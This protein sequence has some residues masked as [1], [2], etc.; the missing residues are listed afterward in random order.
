MPN[1]LIKQFENS[2]LGKERA[3]GKPGSRFDSNEHK[4]LLTSDD[5]VVVSQHGLDPTVPCATGTLPDLTRSSSQNDYALRRT[6]PVTSSYDHRYYQT[7]PGCGAEPPSIDLG[8]NFPSM[9]EEWKTHARY[10]SDTQ[11]PYPRS[12]LS[13]L[14]DPKTFEP[15][16]KYRSVD[17]SASDETY[18]GSSFTTCEPSR[19]SLPLIG[20]VGCHKLFIG[21]GG[22]TDLLDYKHSSFLDHHD[23]SASKISETPGMNMTKGLDSRPSLHSLGDA[24]DDP[25]ATL[26]DDGLRWQRLWVS[27]PSSELVP[28]SEDDSSQFHRGLLKDASVISNDSLESEE[29]SGYEELRP[30]QLM[31][32]DGYDDEYYPT[33]VSSRLHSDNYQKRTSVFSRLSK[34]P[35]TRRQ[36]KVVY[37]PY[38][39]LSLDQLL[40]VLSRRKDLL[41]DVDKMVPQKSSIQDDDQQFEKIA[42]TEPMLSTSVGEFETNSEEVAEEI[43]EIPFLNFKRRSEVQKVEGGNEARPDI[44][45]HR[46]E[47]SLRKR[48]RLVRPSFCEDECQDVQKPSQEIVRGGVLV[49][50]GEA[51]NTV[52]GDSSVRIYEESRNKNS[53]SAAECTLSCV[54]N[55]LKIGSNSSNTCVNDILIDTA[56]RCF[57]K[58]LADH[59]VVSTGN[60]KHEEKANTALHAG[61]VDLSVLQGYSELCV[62]KVRE[63][64]AASL[65]KTDNI[66]SEDYLAL[67]VGED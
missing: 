19:V 26:Q 46:G 34:A 17:V 40:S 23:S 22:C 27:G 59:S 61:G 39:N 50:N 31:H 8:M 63:V 16:S 20:S 44:E 2:Y 58:S 66:E 21:S 57:L 45:G 62:Q 38:R 37:E 24:H 6:F 49:K 64:N 32:D 56:G 30:Y 7:V 4:P 1:K 25:K 35:E 53:S 18:E 65:V 14:S 41:S 12:Q 33:S 54:T 52:D 60:A 13:L 67:Q 10:F 29:G 47:G 42:D 9:A 51:A 43:S 36:Y 3:C 48:T 15:S 28:L 11:V 5:S 55:T